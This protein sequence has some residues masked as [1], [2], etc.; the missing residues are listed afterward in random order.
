MK[1][2]NEEM[3]NQCLPGN[4]VTPETLF[5]SGLMHFSSWTVDVLLSAC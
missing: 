3:A 5:L 1:K 2:T 4:G